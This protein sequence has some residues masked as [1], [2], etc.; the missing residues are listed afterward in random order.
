MEGKKQGAIDDSQAA[1]FL[2]VEGLHEVGFGFKVFLR[3]G[4]VRTHRHVTTFRQIISL[5]V[6]GPLHC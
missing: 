5:H 4:E 6:V 1:H 3:A 2:G